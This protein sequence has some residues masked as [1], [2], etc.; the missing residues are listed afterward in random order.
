MMELERLR[1]CFVFDIVD[2]MPCDIFSFRI[3]NGMTQI[4][5][6]ETF[7]DRWAPMVGLPYA[8]TFTEV[9]FIIMV[10]NGN[11]GF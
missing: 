3:K 11:N 1:R 10:N 5:H 4:Y 6:K 9:F 2:F 7:D 8:V